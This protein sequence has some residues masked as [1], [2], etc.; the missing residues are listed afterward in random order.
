MRSRSL[1]LFVAFF[2]LSPLLASAQ[3]TLLWTD[4]RTGAGVRYSAG[5]PYTDRWGLTPDTFRGTNYSAIQDHWMWDDGFEARGFAHLG[6]T[7]LP[8]SPGLGG[9]F[10]G[11]I[12]DA[13]T[14]AEVFASDIGSGVTQH[15]FEVAWGWANGHIEFSI[16]RP[17]NWSWIGGWQGNTYNTGAY[18]EVSAIHELIDLGTGFAYVN[19]AR[20]SINGSGDWV[21]YFSRSGT[22]PAGTYRLTWSHESL[23]AGGYTVFGFYST[24][25]GGAPLVSCINSEFRI[26]DVPAPSSLA[27]LGAAGCVAARRRR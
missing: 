13:C 5:G 22:I 27:L 10:S 7:Y 8:S 14:S 26:W 17:M 4:N 24:A 3:G 21:E 6:A 1:A 11:A 15:D 12:L 2:G 9:P 18:N 23:V 16:S 20:A 25:F 19:E